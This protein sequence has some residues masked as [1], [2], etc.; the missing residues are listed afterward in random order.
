LK[1]GGVALLAVSNVTV[2]GDFA[3]SANTCTGATLTNG[4]QCEVS[5]TFTP[6]AVGL[7]TGTLSFTDNSG[8]SPQTVALS[9][10]GIEPGKF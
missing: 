10:T 8:T 2:N 4:K 3:I 7:Q 9:G 1:N 5:V 6:T